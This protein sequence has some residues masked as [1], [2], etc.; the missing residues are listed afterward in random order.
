MHSDPAMGRCKHLI[1]LL[2]TAELSF[3]NKEV[4]STQKQASAI[5]MCD[6][7]MILS[8]ALHISIFPCT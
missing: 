2:V 7:H 1:L 8:S 4:T 6:K 5:I 3:I